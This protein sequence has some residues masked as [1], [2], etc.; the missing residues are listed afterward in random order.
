MLRP[1]RELIEQFPTV[2][3]ASKV[4]VE[5]GLGHCWPQSAPWHRSHGLPVQELYIPP[6]KA[7][8]LLQGS[9]QATEG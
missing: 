7:C 9:N 3:F 2:Q 8:A 5:A 1:E 6:S 4:E